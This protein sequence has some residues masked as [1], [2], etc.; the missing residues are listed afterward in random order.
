MGVI[1]HHHH[2][3][4]ISLA[5]VIILVIGI[6]IGAFLAANLGGVTVAVDLEAV[7]IGLMFTIIALLLIVCSLVLEIREVVQSKKR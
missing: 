7:K 5:T 4:Y 6:W 2:R 3:L 1:G